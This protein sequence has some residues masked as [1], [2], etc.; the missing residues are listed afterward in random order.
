MLEIGS[1]SCYVKGID[2]SVITSDVVPGLADVVIDGQSLPFDDSSLRAILLVHVFHHIPDVENF[3]TEAA[4]V[5]APNGVISMIDVAH[6][7]FAQFFFKMMHPEP[8]LT[9]APEWKLHDPQGHMDANQAL[10]WIVFE[11]DRSKFERRYPQLRIERKTLLPWL[12]YLLSGGV[13]RRCL[14]PIRLSGGVARM[15]R[16]LR[17]THPFCSLH[18]HITVRKIT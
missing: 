5:L 16:L 3:L 10:S 9:K 12:G 11:R 15:D 8:Y 2:G 17:W 13:T 7:T 1:G 18:W 4:R 14:V 6:T